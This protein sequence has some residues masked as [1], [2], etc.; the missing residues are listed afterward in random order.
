MNMSSAQ[1]EKDFE[2]E[3]RRIARAKWPSAKYSG[4]EM[5]DGRERDG[6]FETEDSINYIEATV[7]AASRKARDDAKKI[8]KSIINHN[9]SATLK[10]AIGWIITKNEPTAEQR[11][12]TQ[13]HGKGQVR[14]VSFAQFQQ[15]LIDVRSYLNARKDH[16]FG[17][18]QDFSTSSNTPSVPF[19]DIG[20]SKTDASKTF[21]VQEIVKQVLENSHFTISGQYGAGKSMFLR[22]I[23]FLLA[24]EYVKNR[25]SKFPVFINLR[26]HSGQ[27]DPVEILERH[28]RGIGFEPPSSLI[29]AWRAGFVIL[30]ID[31]YDEVTS[32]GV[33]G[34]WRKLKE[35][36]RR[37]LEGVRKLIR[38]S[39]E[40][41]VIVTGRSYYFET[42]DELTNSLGLNRPTAVIIDEF[43]DQQINWFLA[44]FPNLKTNNNLP[45]WLP[46]R[47]LL[48]GYLASKGFLTELNDSNKCPDAVDGWNFLLERIYTREEGI[49]SNLDGET[50]R[51]I[52]ERLATCARVT[53]D[54]LG[55]ITRSDLFSAFSEICGYEPDEQGI[56]AIQRLPGLGIY[57][58]EDE[59]RCFVDKELVD[60]CVGRE[61]LRFLE[62]P[63]DAVKNR[64]WMDAMNSCDRPINRASAELVNRSIESKPVI[65][66]Y[67]RQAVNFMKN[68]SDINCVL[69]DI[70]VMAIVSNSPLDLPL[71][72]HGMFFLADALELDSSIPDFSSISFYHCLFSSIY[73]DPNTPT[74][75]MPGFFGCLFE[76][77]HGRTSVNDLPRN[78]FD[79]HCEFSEFEGTE[80]NYSIRA[81]MLSI[82]EKILLITLRKLFIQSLSGRIE[83]ALYRG[84]NVDERRY[85][86]DILK[87]LKR[88]QLVT[89]YSRGNGTIWLPT[90]RALERVKR[91]LNA[92]TECG[93]EIITEAKSL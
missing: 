86:D 9:R 55:P 47:P 6:V 89:E 90:R 39:G 33:Q 23:Y 1:H 62:S 75:K 11:A 32:L 16:K 2:N 26:E 44:N 77:I 59:S 56:L 8:F 14:I 64:L 87:L 10:V 83:S 12:E 41:G 66:G 52:L 84:L 70:A 61:L 91:I 48:L 24:E 46:T 36:R 60:V 37:S 28:A 93:E 53:E 30:L 22:Q 92:P 72:V 82:G 74:A 51:L 73:L 79:D 68:R 17:S 88:H 71:G 15:S 50:L 5:L 81:G 29:R 40:I 13:E 76:Q 58:A 25:T 43:S 7:S 3:V 54:Q 34:A 38:E 57:R 80:T 69:G 21:S 27:K 19:I 85:V 42:L 65:Q 78:K 20:L 49:E 45:T 63:Y 67:L 31:G 4:A 35:L 18:V